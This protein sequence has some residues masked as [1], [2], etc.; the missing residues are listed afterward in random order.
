MKLTTSQL[1]ALHNLA[2]HVAN[3]EEGDL[4]VKSI[5]VEVDRFPV[6]VDLRWDSGA[7]EYVLDLGQFQ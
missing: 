2:N 4:T 5:A 3:H 1:D 6:E 7:G